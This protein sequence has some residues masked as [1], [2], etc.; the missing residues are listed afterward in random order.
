VKVL[1]RKALLKG[2]IAREKSDISLHVRRRVRIITFLHSCALDSPLTLLQKTTKAELEAT[3][4]GHIITQTTLTGYIHVR[5]NKGSLRINLR[6][7]RRE[8][9][10]EWIAKIHWGKVLLLGFLFTIISVVVRQVEMSM[11]MGYYT[12]PRYFGRVESPYECLLPARRPRSFLSSST[13]ATFF[14]GIAITIIY[15]YLKEYLPKAIITVI[16][17]L[18]IYLCNVVRF[19]FYTADVVTI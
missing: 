8:Y 7:R 13:I 18:R 1:Y 3:M 10:G 19:R 11:T 15:Y 16:S 5:I 2:P 6:P 4:S 14:T 17:F 12:D 9:D